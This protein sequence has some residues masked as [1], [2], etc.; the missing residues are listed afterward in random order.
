MGA[1]E[2]GGLAPAR[3]AGK[4]DRAMKLGFLGPRG[5]RPGL[6]GR[7]A[8]SGPK[9]APAKLPWTLAVASGKGGTG[10]TVLASNL[11]TQLCMDGF[12]VAFFDADLGVANAHLLLG[13]QAQRSIAQVLGGKISLK[14]AA[15]PSP[16]GPWIVPGGSGISD[17][18]SLSAHEFLRLA[19]DFR[20]WE[21]GMDFLILD[22]AAGIS[23]Q[24]ILFLQAADDL[25]VVTNP[26]FTAMTDAYALI[27]VLHM[28]D[29][30]MRVHVV[31]NRIRYRG[32]E[33]EVFERIQ[34]VCSRFL[35]KELNFLGG[36]P[37]DDEVPRS[38][39]ARVPFVV[40]APRSGAA[41]ALRGIK[42]KILDLRPGGEGEPGLRPEGYGDR[43][44]RALRG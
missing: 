14:E 12:K 5:K 39:G 40:G 38:V 34:A 26:D 20:A 16:F 43:L 3:D 8:L 36:L 1:R 21:E 9:T 2:G 7:F 19:R 35:G 44:A 28:R 6:L 18:A 27:K 29:P 22:C 4:E 24:T 13:V 30:G 37:D 23:V 11:A 10:K 15:L 32:Q 25:L 17:L 41:C 31:V 42:D 33:R